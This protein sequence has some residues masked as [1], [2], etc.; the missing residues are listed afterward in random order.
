VIDVY[1]D[2]KG[3]SMGTMLSLIIVILIFVLTVA[4]LAWKFG[5]ETTSTHKIVTENSI[6]IR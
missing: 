4:F 2:N 6:I 3:W 1:L 5:I